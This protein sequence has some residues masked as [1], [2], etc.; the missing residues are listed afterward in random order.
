MDTLIRTTSTIEQVI[1]ELA[2]LRVLREQALSG[3]QLAGE[4][5]IRQSMAFKAWV[6]VTMPQEAIGMARQSAYLMAVAN[7]EGL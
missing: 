6:D 3:D 2:K 4:T 7:R 1:E 5:Y